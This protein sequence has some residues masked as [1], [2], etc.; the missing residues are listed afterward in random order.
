MAYFVLAVA[1]IVAAIYV[2]VVLGLGMMDGGRAGPGPYNE[3]G[4]HPE[5]LLVVAVATMGVIALGSLYKTSQLASG[6]EAVAL[7]MGCRL[8]DG[9]T[10]N[11]AERRLLNIVEE[12][13]IASGV[14]V[15]PVYVMDGEPSINAFAAG[16][17]PADAVIAVSRGSLTYLDR[18]EIQGV[19]AHEFSHILNGDMRLNL[20]LVGIL[21]GILLLAVIGWY[22]L[23]S[24]R[25]SGR[26]SRG[27][28]KGG[29]ALL[30]IIMIGAGLLV[31]GSIGLFFG[32]LIKSAVSRQ[33][34]YLADASAVQFTRLPDGI[35]GA[36]K[37][38]GGLPETSKIEDAHAEEIS[39]M[40]FGSAFG[41]FH[42][43]L[44]ATHPPLADRVLRIDPSFDGNFPQVV[45]PVRIA[46]Q[47]VERKPKPAEKRE[48]LQAL[49][50]AAGAPLDPSGILDRIGVPGLEQIVAAAAILEG[51]PGPLQN[52]AHEPYGA[53][54]VIY[55]L[56][57]DGDDT[58]R[59]P[60]LQALREKAEIQSYQ[61]TERL[62]PVVDQ[63]GDEHRLA[64]VDVAMP[65]LK[66]LSKVQFVQFRDNVD[67]LIRADRKI[68]L[69]E[70]TVQLTVIRTLDIHFG[71]AAPPAVRYRRLD[72]LTDPMIDVL[73]VLAH[74]G[75]RDDDEAHL[76]FDAA[77]QRLGRTASMR[78]RSDCTLKTFDHALAM[79]AETAPRLKR[80]ILEASIACVMAD[81]QVSARE[82]QLVRAVAANLGV[83]LPPIAT[84]G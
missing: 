58:M 5:L 38:I 7:M 13:A 33:R 74:S 57:L 64:L 75:A 41:S 25:F 60:Q 31:V 12:M 84:P 55:A 43:Q 9:Q 56:L 32:R 6:G 36:L 20:R 4:W 2:I 67:A 22:V 82:S 3:F 70:Y 83:P 42:W 18:D 59:A 30:L 44:F 62:A 78:D 40:F 11:L 47:D 53:R 69:L 19:I 46:P 1:G 79:L 68:D 52:A 45:L 34:E 51:I 77:W 23:R 29:G 15:P 50:R 14:P 27:G 81:R 39:H 17:E 76:A 49:G 35:A 54:A 8:V 26:R 10:D 24:M 37:K 63:L 61:E 66:K 21:H 80:D 28:D 71:L 72:A 73:S 65:A 16:F 48:P